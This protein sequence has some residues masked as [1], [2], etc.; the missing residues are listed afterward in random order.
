LY[1]NQEAQATA[2]DEESHQ[3]LLALAIWTPARYQNRAKPTDLFAPDFDLVGMLANLRGNMDAASTFSEGFSPLS[4]LACYART[5]HKVAM[6]S[7]H[8]S[9]GNC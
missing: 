1:S 5:P 7:Y 6:R 9:I 8:R 4:L 2:L 3:A